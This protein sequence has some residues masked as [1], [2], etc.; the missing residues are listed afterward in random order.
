MT[1]SKNMAIESACATKAL[2]KDDGYL[3]QYATDDRLDELLD[4]IHDE[5]LR[6][7]HDAAIVTTLEEMFNAHELE[8]MTNFAKGV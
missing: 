2:L 6:R 8:L 7:R 1:R 3:L 4:A 5:R